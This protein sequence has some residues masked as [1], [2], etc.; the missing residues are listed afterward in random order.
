MT[1]IRLQ[2]SFHHV[3][4]NILPFST[5]L[6][7]L[8]FAMLLFGSNNP[9]GV[10]G[11]CRNGFLVSIGFSLVATLVFF[12][13]SVIGEKTSQVLRLFFLLPRPR[14]SA[15]T[16]SESG[17]C[18]SWTRARLFLDALLF[19][20]SLAT[21]TSKDSLLVIFFFKRPSCASSQVSVD[22]IKY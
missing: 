6:L 4:L 22:W 18:N 1:Q 10:R 15:S 8:I 3:S 19:A 20:E 12:D 11:N 14:G 5:W 17:G 9:N 2:F 7:E 13:L 21:L 16:T